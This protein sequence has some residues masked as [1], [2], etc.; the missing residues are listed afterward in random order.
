MDDYATLSKDYA[1]LSKDYV[2]L[3]ESACILIEEYVALNT[4]NYMQPT[5]HSTIIKDVIVL[6]K[7][8]ISDAFAEDNNDKITKIVEDGLALFYKHIAPPRS[9]GATFIRTK[10]NIPK[11]QQKIH[12][13]QTV[14]QPEQRT[15][16]WYM[17]RY[18]HLTASNIWKA[19]M[20]ESMKNQLIYEKCQPLNAGKYSNINLES[21]MHWGQRYEP[22]SVMLY[23]SLYDTKVSDFGC[24]PHK[25]ISFLAAS[26]DG[27]N[28]LDSS[29]R[30][31][32]MLEVKNIVN[33]EITGIPKLEYWIQMQLQLE[34]CDLNECDFFETRFVEYPDVEAYNACPSKQKGMMMLFMTRNGQP[35]YEYGGVPPVSPP[36]E[37][38]HEG[39]PPETPLSKEKHEGIPPVSSLSKEKHEG[40][41]PVSSL[42]KEK[43]EGIPPV[44]SQNSGNSSPDGGFGAC[45]AGGGTPPWEEAMMLKNKDLTWLKN[46]YWKVDQVSCVLVLRNKR[47]FAAA[48]PHLIELWKTIENEKKN[49]YAHRAP[50]K[51]KG[52]TSSNNDI[53]VKKMS[54]DNTIEMPAKCFITIAT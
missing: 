37:E 26:P 48:L 3:S 13:L 49:G 28:T 23:E 34:V 32:R 40:I 41:P 20:S 38:K 44:S 53:K 24:I 18:I 54:A 6:L 52:S 33:R 17:F 22:V 27:I 39:I 25:T 19:F 7:N 12:Y 30:F 1:T 14:P 51:G 31:G 21:P 4:I 16:E 8:T 10:P 15:P 36:W 46:I 29:S 50:K 35:V 42:S 45:V 43:H 9:S 2:T 11:L 47:W 5:F